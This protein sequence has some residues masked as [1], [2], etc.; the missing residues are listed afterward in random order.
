[1]KDPRRGGGGNLSKVA[2]TKGRVRVAENLPE[3]E[4]VVLCARQTAKNTRKVT[5]F[6]QVRMRHRHSS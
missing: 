3:I 5:I 6:V 2:A 1:L 4:P